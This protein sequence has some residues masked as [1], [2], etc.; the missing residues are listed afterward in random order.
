MH[1]WMSIEDMRRLSTEARKLNNMSAKDRADL[2]W[3]SRSSSRSTSAAVRF[4][5][6]CSVVYGD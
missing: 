2:K 4:A 5:M 6:S 1:N 3:A